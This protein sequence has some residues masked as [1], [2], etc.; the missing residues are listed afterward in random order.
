MTQGHSQKKESLK[1]KQHAATNK[2]AVWER[3]A[4]IG[5]HE[6]TK[7]CWGLYIQEK[8]LGEHKFTGNH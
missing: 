7:M 6:V 1:A 5:Q 3:S 8:R 2:S 4:L